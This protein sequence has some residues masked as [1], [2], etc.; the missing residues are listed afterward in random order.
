MS[1][2]PQGGEGTVFLLRNSAQWPE[3]KGIWSGTLGSLILEAMG[4]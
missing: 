1:L 4:F 3:V 2:P